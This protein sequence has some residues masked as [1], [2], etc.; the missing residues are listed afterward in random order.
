MS[1]CNNSKDAK[2]IKTDTSVE[3]TDTASF[4]DVQVGHGVESVS[5]ETSSDA[6]Q[7]NVCSCK[8]YSG[9]SG[10]NDKCSCGHERH[11]HYWH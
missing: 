10:T 6:L 2:N 11:K 7:C 5:T 3:V 4:E 9:G 1:A 8:H